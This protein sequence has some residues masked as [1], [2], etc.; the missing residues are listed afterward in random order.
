LQTVR[1]YG[2]GAQCILSCYDFCVH[3]LGQ[4][5]AFGTA[6]YGESLIESIGKDVLTER[7][8]VVGYFV[9]FLMDKR[10]DLSKLVYREEMELKYIVHVISQ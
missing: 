8:L 1:Q 4:S 6:F 2:G 10:V 9:S 3:C 7:S 5:M